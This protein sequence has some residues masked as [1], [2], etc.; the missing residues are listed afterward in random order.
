MAIKAITTDSFR[1]DVLKTRKPVLVKFWAPWC[2]YCRALAPALESIEKQY[3]NLLSVGRINFDTETAVARRYNIHKL[4]TLLLFINGAVAGFL[5]DPSSEKEID[6]FLKKMLRLNVEV[7]MA[8]MY[9]I[10]IIGGGPGGYSAALYAARA[11]LHV[12][13]IEKRAI[14]GQAIRSENIENYPGFDAG[15]DGLSLSEKMQRGA[16]RFG[17]EMV[18]DEVRRVHLMQP[19][20]VIEAAKQTY[21]APTVIL[22]TGAPP[23]KLGVEGEEEMLGRGVHYYAACRSMMY[24]RKTVAVIGEG[25]QAAEAAMLLSRIAKRVCLVHRGDHMEISPAYA[26]KLKMMRNIERYAGS[27][28]QAFLHANWVSC[29]RIREQ[30]GGELWNLPC[31]GA[32]ICLG[33]VPE[34]NLLHGQIALDKQGYILANETTIIN[35]PGVFAAGDVRTKLLRGILTAAADGAA[36]A[37]QAERYIVENI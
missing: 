6:A 21:Q 15:I 2:G 27:E 19:V 13:V 9:D 10:V 20:K 11:G 33:G 26:G 12:A 32:F 23:R 25:E 5:I 3:E 14:G 4:P 1:D 18:T 22:A 8:N 35:L 24:R 7:C 28:I 29:I 37:Q 31:D 36:A 34:T 30:R 16:E 17:A